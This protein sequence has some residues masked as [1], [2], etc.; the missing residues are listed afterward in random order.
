[1]VIGGVDDFS[2][3]EIVFLLKDDDD[4][5]EI[6]CFNLIYVFILVFFSG[7]EIEMVVKYFERG[8][9]FWFEMLYVEICF[10]GSVIIEDI[11]RRFNFLW[12]LMKGFFDVLF[13]FFE[14]LF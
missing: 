14:S 3:E 11:E 2:Y 7:E 9:V 4:V 10:G 6:E 12:N 5:N 1:M 13:V 8:G